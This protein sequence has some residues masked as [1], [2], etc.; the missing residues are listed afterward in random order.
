ML[1][2]I[3]AA[4]LLGT[5]LPGC[6]PPGQG[7]PGRADH[8]GRVG[9]A[10]GAGS[11]ADLASGLGHL[12]EAYARKDRERWIRYGAVLEIDDGS[13]R[14]THDPAA[15]YD[16]MHALGVTDLAFGETSREGTRVRTRA[17]YRLTGHDTA[18]QSEV[19]SWSASLDR[20][21]RSEPVL[22]WE[23]AGTTTHRGRYTLGMGAAEP[24]TVVGMVHHCD[25]AVE[26]VRAA[27]GQE[28]V[29]PVLLLPDSAELFRRWGAIPAGVASP[30]AVTVGVVRDGRAEGADRVVLDTRTVQALAPRGRVVVLTHEATHLAMRRDLTGPRPAWLEEGT[31]EYIAY[32]R[33]GLAP[34]Q[35]AAPLLRE[36]VAGR[37]PR[38]LPSAE[39]FAGPRASAAYGA[40]WLACVLIAEHAGPQGLM[41][42]VR[43]AQGDRLTAPGV[44]KPLRR[45]TGWDAATFEDRWRTR[46]AALPG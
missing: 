25:S 34:A 31:C 38:H 33:T 20:L 15:T 2:A 12:R 45:H 22:P 43:A 37:A 21:R 1:R 9:T 35:I 30:S 11:S 4:A 23:E 46:V 41:S 32:A 42:F 29:R 19:L 14:R 40:A 7:Q 3:A 6:R 8:V 13:P 44:E 24:D 26:E 36:V 18:S 5:A 10:P 39:E 27:W 16:L 28:P 17:S